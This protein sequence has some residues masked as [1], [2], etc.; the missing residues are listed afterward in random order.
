MLSRS[1]RTFTAVSVIRPWPVETRHLGAYELPP[2][3]KFPMARLLDRQVPVRWATWDLD[4]T[5]V[6]GRAIPRRARSL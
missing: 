4:T 5:A 2:D 6:T 3:R 1:I